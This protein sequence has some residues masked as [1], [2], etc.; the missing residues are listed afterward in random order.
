[1]Y[2]YD[3]INKLY[4]EKHSLPDNQEYILLLNELNKIQIQYDETPNTYYYSLVKQQRLDNLNYLK[5]LLDVQ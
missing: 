5:Q 2:K 3:Y 1:M 4:L